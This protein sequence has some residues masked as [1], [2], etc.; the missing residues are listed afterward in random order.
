MAERFD[1]QVQIV[2]QNLSSGAAQGLQSLAGEFQRFGDIKLQEF[3][4]EQAKTALRKGQEAF[5]Q[6]KKPSFA[7]ENVFIGRDNAIAFNKGLE[8]SYVSSLSNDIRAGLSQAETENQADTLG[9]TNAAGAFRSGV[10]KE[11]DPRVALKVQQSFDEQITLGMSRVS[12]NQFNKAR[13]EQR[14]VSDQN[15]ETLS[16]AAFTGARNL[17]MTEVRQAGQELLTAIDTGV[18]AGLYKPSEAA[19][20]KQGIQAEA[21]IQGKLGELEQLMQAEGIDAGSNFVRDMRDVDVEGLDEKAKKSMLTRMTARVSSANSERVQ[22]LN[23]RK[24]DTL[25]EVNS[26]ILE[27]Q[28]PG[29]D[30]DA[31]IAKGVEMF[32]KEEMTGGEL[33]RLFNSIN[34]GKAQRDDLEADVSAVM[35]RTS[36]FES[37]QVSQRGVDEYY[38]RYM[39]TQAVNAPTPA[40]RNAEV[41]QFVEQSGMVPSQFQ[42]QV[43]NNINTGDNTLVAESIDFIDRIDNIPGVDPFDK[44]SKE[45][46]AFA[47]SV[48]ALSQNVL[49]EK[50][51]EMARLNTDM[52]NAAMVAARDDQIKI[53][54]RPGKQNR[55][56]KDYAKI[57]RA[58]GDFVANS[59]NEANM[60]KE[61]RD[62][63]ESLYRLGSPEDAAAGTALRTLQT[64]WQEDGVTG[65]TYKYPVSQYVNDF[66]GAENDMLDSVKTAIGK[67]QFTS[68]TGLLD[69]VPKASDIRLYSDDRTAREATARQPTYLA[70]LIHPET[71][72]L[73]NLTGFRWEPPYAK[74]QANA[75]DVDKTVE[76]IRA[77][78]R[79]KAAKLEEAKLAVGQVPFFGGF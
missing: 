28:Q 77:N 54:N 10:L 42:A 7:D 78:S 17:N 12:R 24:A 15:I 8:H 26:L 21:T 27:S 30:S 75:Q 76:T 66:E 5:T 53:W 32:E 69:F 39:E 38:R 23:N 33:S 14:A 37:Q 45:Q 16:D 74:E 70:Y 73:I 44:F 47:N 11:V 49:P 41:A 25:I 31:L 58:E 9:Y 67:K 51:V 22:I 3:K 56:F 29:A 48:L 79:R 35:I 20:L 55:D 6:G 2:R 46:R 71:K 36:G 40:I 63:F 43:L 65:R 57:V 59:I 68:A 13:E 19:K 60:A 1:Q 61:Y 52:S 34:T 4:E 64:N 50:A 72:E 62:T 18:A